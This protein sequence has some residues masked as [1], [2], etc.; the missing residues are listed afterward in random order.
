MGMRIILNGWTHADNNS[1]GGVGCENQHWVVNGTELGVDDGLHLMPLV[2]F[3]GVV[4]D[5]G[6]QVSSRVTMEAVTIGQLRFVVLTIWLDES[7]NM[8]KWLLNF[9]L[10]SVNKRE[11]SSVL[12]RENSFGSVSSLKV[13]HLF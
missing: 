1:P 6:R 9:L 8:F 11:V 7:L 12:L 10:H 4:S 3:Q 13:S 5:R 2:H